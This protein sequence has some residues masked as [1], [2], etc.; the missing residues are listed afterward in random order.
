MS[1]RQA[2]FALLSAVALFVV[3]CSSGGGKQAAP[4]TTTTA[5]ASPSHVIANVG[6]CPK[7]YGS[8]T[9]NRLN[10]GVHGLDKTL[11]PITATRVRVCEYDA[12]GGATGALI[13][14][15]VLV[16]ATAKQFENETNRLPP[17]LVDNSGAPALY[18]YRVLFTSA[19]QRVD[20]LVRLDLD[21]VTNGVLHSQPTAQWQYDL[22]LAIAGTP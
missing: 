16:S 7:Q 15:A 1:R 13:A 9:L 11:V 19:A 14:S 2:L 4:T 3:G 20:V 17:P 6:P 12:R 22:R 10:G 5:T 18:S 21:G 8:T